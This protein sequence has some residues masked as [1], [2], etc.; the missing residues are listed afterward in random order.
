M[1]SASTSS[2]RSPPTA[3]TCGCNGPAAPARS[4]CSSSRAVSGRC[5]PTAPPPPSS[6]R[7]T[8]T[9]LDGITWLHVTAYS[10]CTEP[11]GSRR[12]DGRRPGPRQRRAGQ[13][14]RL[15]GGGGRGVRPDPVRRRARC[16]RPRRRV[17][18]RRRGADCSPGAAGRARRQGR[19]AARGASRIPMG[20]PTEVDVPRPRRPSPTRPGR[21]TPSPP[22]SSP[23][24]STGR[25]RSDAARAGVAVAARLARRRAGNDRAPAAVRRRMEL[26]DALEFVRDRHRG[27]LVTIKRDGRPQ[28]SNIALR[29]R[30]RRRDP[31]LGHGLPGQ[32]GE[33]PP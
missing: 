15:V 28:L 18:Q 7:S 9:W 32:D 20:A 23:P 25:R 8:R 31:H 2:R 12:G 11:A 14:R 19:A 33:R 13:R 24:C 27:V 4:P 21:G 30:R 1:R 29:P 3:S 22:G 17:R 6:R 10:L 5:S 26:N 16:R